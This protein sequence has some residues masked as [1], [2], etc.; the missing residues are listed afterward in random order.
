MPG[1]S[2]SMIIVAMA[3]WCVMVTAGRIMAMVIAPVVVVARTGF[4]VYSSPYLWLIV[5]WVCSGLDGTAGEAKRKT[6]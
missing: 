5:V 2:G 1:E 3:A 4:I 6:E